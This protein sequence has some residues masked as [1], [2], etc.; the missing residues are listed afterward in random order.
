MG[1]IEIIQKKIRRGE[2]SKEEIA[3][4]IE[5]FTSG[6][7]ADYQAS[8]LITAIFINKMSR[9]ETINLTMAMA[10][11]GDTLDLSGIEGIKVD[12]HS[13]GGVG[14]KT[15]LIVGPMVA[16]LG[17]PVAKMSGRALGFGGGTIDKLESIKNFKIELTREQFISN[18]NRMKMAVCAQTGV[19]APADKKIY[20]LR[21]VTGTVEDLSLIASSVMSKKIAGGADAI[22]LDVKAG[23]GAFMKTYDDAL[24]LAKIMVDIGNGVGRKTVALITGMDQPL[25]YAVGNALEV[26]EAIA[27]VKGR[28]PADLMEVCVT[29]AAYMILLAGKTGDLDAAKKLAA[30]TTRNGSAYKKLQ[31]FVEAQ[32]GDVSYITNPDTFPLASNVVAV[33]SPAEGFVRSIS[34]EGIGSISMELGAGR[35]KKDDA[36]DYAAGIMLNKKIGDAVKKGE[37]LAW[38]HTNDRDRIPKAQERLLTCYTFGDVQPEPVALIYKVITA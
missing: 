31:E 10:N 6:K 12:K 2:L 13:T 9:E 4:F 23:G 37:T 33:T 14:D 28:G 20:A 8:A 32:G 16:A 18:V 5:N 11:S 19:L 21:D 26:K 15:T 1:I 30:E 36:I 38:L 27:A 17:V 22:V 25:G 3:Y 35:I 29:L 34:A 7:I 24:Q